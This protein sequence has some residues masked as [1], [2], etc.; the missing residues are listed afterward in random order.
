MIYD[1]GSLNWILQCVYVYIYN[2]Y[3][4][5]ICNLSK[6]IQIL[7]SLLMG[8]Q[9]GQLSGAQHQPAWR[10]ATICAG[11]RDEELPGASHAAT[12]WAITQPQTMNKWIGW[13]WWSI[14]KRSATTSWT[15]CAGTCWIQLRLS[16]LVV[17]PMN[18]K[19]DQWPW[20][21]SKK[22]CTQVIMHSRYST[23]L[24]KMEWN[25]NEVKWRFMHFAHDLS[26]PHLPK[27]VATTRQ[28]GDP[29]VPHLK[30]VSY[31]LFALR[32]AQAKTGYPH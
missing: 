30:T 7:W 28:T 19:A 27:K 16:R 31:A 8:T 20:G 9:K 11:L 14:G 3:D 1:D 18:T 23:L 32:Q 5:I 29:Q 26:I 22:T 4:N 12:I 17:L 21:C 24:S 13:K 2:I 25:M 15:T 6:S 10:F